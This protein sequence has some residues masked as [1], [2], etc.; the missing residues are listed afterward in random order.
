M[1]GAELHISLG[2]YSSRFSE[3]ALAAIM[4]QCALITCD[5]SIGL[6]DS[7]L[8]SALV[9]ISQ[10]LE[11]LVKK[12]EFERSVV[13]KLRPERSA[14][15]P[16]EPQGDAAREVAMGTASQRFD[17]ILFTLKLSEL[18]HQMQIKSVASDRR[19][20]TGVVG[21]LLLNIVNGQLALLRDEWLDGVDRI[22]R[23]VWQKQRETI[24]S[25]FVRDVLLPEAMTLIGNRESTVMSNVTLA[26]QRTHLE[27]PHDAQHHLAMEICKLKGE[28]ANRYE[29]EARELE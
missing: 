4:G 5:Q 13:Q 23:D 6:V 26:A 18:S 10:R 3:A 2:S 24:A 22:A 15:R 9:E 7:R 14:T 25:D 12:I 17:R 29:I 20:G 28:V 1:I 8:P 21:S 27:D 16:A 11:D 19:A